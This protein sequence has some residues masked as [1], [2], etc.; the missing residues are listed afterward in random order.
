MLLDKTEDNKTN[1]SNNLIDQIFQGKLMSIYRCSECGY[2]TENVIN[3]NTLYFSIY[4]RCEQLYNCSSLEMALVKKMVL[5]IFDHPVYC[6]ICI[7]NVI[8]HFNFKRL[9]LKNIICL[10]NFLKYYL[11]L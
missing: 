6:T 3:Y 7:N 8:Y 2:E 9:L 11:F 5:E 4:D 10:L 1:V